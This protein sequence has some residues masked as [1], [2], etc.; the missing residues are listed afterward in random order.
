MC[1]L[2]ISVSGSKKG[3]FTFTGDVEHLMAG[4]NINHLSKPNQ[5]GPGLTI[6]LHLSSYASR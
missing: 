1:T 6:E 5:A 3:L 4:R 2:S